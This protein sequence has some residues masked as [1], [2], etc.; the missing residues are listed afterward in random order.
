M[1]TDKV[2]QG[3]CLDV[4]KTFESD[5]VD[6]I[7]TSPPYWAVRDY[8]VEEQIGM[9][10]QPQQYIDKIVEIMKECKRVLKSAGTIWLNLGDSF[11]TKSGSGQGSNF[12][13][14]HKQLSEGRDILN[15]AHQ[16]IRGKY[17]SNW[18][19]SKQRL[20]I[21]HRIAIA[22]QDELGLICRNDLTW[23]KQ[24]ANWKTKNSWG[25]SMPTSVQDRLNTNSEQIFLFVKSQDYFFDLDAIRVPHKTQED[26]LSGLVRNRLFNYDSK[27]NNNPDNY[28]LNNDKRYNNSKYETKE[29]ESSVR[30]GFHKDRDSNDFYNQNGKN[31]G[32]CIMFPLE[33]SHEHHFAQFPESL[34][35]FCIKAGCPEFVCKKCGKARIK[36]LEHNKIT[37]TGEEYLETKKTPYSIQERNGFIKVR[38]LPLIEDF[39]DYINNKRKEIKKTIEEVEIVF[40]NQASH[41]WFNGES[42]PSTDDYKK[43]KEILNL[44]NEYDEALTKEFFKPAEKQNYDYKSVGWSD[45]GHNAGFSGG[46][47]LDPFAGSGTTLKV[48][49]KLGRRFLGIELNENYI[50]IIKK[51]LKQNTLHT[52]FEQ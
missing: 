30:Q 39:A 7:V 51:R 16:E 18:L 4:L 14:K 24:M 44:D 49:K 11:Y 25:S 2:Y 13:E 1:E 40:G 3:N 42:F 31:P 12:L 10:E 41:H 29:Q 5:S 50:E 46:I 23:I 43:L 28:L 34:P 19:Q 48:A 38:K 20:L 8:G 52:F 9:E 6:C 47:V 21:P 33:P 45:C 22:C 36:I 26:R 37:E 35:D 27:V 32:D 17:K 15:K